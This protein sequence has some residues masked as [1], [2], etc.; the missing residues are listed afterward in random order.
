MK[1]NF[2]QSA[3]ATLFYLGVTPLLEEPQIDWQTPFILAMSWQIT[4]SA[5]RCLCDFH[6]VDQTRQHGGNILAAVSGA[7][8]NGDHG[9]AMVWRG[10]DTAEHGR[11]CPGKCRHLSCH[12][13]FI[14]CN[15]IAWRSRGVQRPQ[16]IGLHLRFIRIPQTDAGQDPGIPRSSQRADQPAARLLRWATSAAEWVG[17]SSPPA[18]MPICS[19]VSSRSARCRPAP[20]AKE[21][22]IA[23]GTA[24]LASRCQRQ[25][26]RHRW[27]RRWFPECWHRYRE[28][29]PARS[30]SATCR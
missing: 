22:T 14:T 21:V 7:A 18:S 29:L 11:V 23:V 19:A 30:T 24:S 4:S 1:G 3:A 6:D 17:P 13:L 28:T 20:A 12:T 15:A 26:S 8:D 9:H 2:L 10:A 25:Y 5:R 16:I 27:Q